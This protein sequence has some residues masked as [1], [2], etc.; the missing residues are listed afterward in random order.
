MSVCVYVCMFVCL[1]ACMPVCLYVCMFAC[2]YV[3]NDS[4]SV[5]EKM[6]LV[7]EDDV[8]GKR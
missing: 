6:M 7:G 4:V 2:L 5:G 1:Y 3:R 8:G